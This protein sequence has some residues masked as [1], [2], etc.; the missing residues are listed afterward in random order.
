MSKENLALWESISKTDPKYTKQVTFGR[1]F[2]SITPVY[3]AKVATKAFGVQ[4]IKWGIVPESE[5]FSEREIAGTI[6]LNYDAVMF[7]HYEGERGEIPIHACTELAAPD[8]S[9]KIRVDAD[10]RK[11]V[12]TSAKSK[13]FSDL[14][15][16]SDIFMGEFDDYEYLKTRQE[17]ANLQRVESKSE[18]KLKAETEYKNY[19]ENQL[20][21]IAESVSM[22]MLEACYKEAVIKAKVRGDEASMRRFALAKDKRKQQLEGVQHDQ[23]V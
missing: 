5:K 23:A 16:C 7:F 21:L 20:K 14:G 10:A 18:E 22:N 13:G 19:I 17:E 6:L 12:V 11:K 1:K 2:T 15:M 4:G 8:K 3:Q 9:G